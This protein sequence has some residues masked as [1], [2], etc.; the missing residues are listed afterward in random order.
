VPDKEIS[1]NQKIEAMRARHAGSGLFR[2]GDRVIVEPTRGVPRPGLIIEISSHEIYGRMAL[3]LV[4][5]HVIRV[6]LERLSRP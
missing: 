4:D 2:R 1:R 5:G 3:V 6:V